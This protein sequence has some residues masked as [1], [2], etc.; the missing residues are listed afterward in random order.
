[1]HFGAVELI[2]DVSGSQIQ[3]DLVER[4][5]AVLQGRLSK[6]P[7]LQVDD[8]SIPRVVWHLGVVELNLATKRG[9]VITVHLVGDGV[10]CGPS[11]HSVWIARLR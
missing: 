7:Y 8:G 5:V 1:M 4:W 3:E 10:G 11:D 9:G 2:F 6:K